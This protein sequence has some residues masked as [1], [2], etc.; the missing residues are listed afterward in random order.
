MTKYLED[1]KTATQTKGVSP[2]TRTEILT[3]AER[4]IAELS[5]IWLKVRRWLRDG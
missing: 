3:R 2:M 4:L 5:D 1:T